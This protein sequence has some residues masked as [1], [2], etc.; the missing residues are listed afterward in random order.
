MSEGFYKY[1]SA[2][3]NAF[4]IYIL[5]QSLLL[6][7]LV[8]GIVVEYLEAF[9]NHKTPVSVFVSLSEEESTEILSSSGTCFDSSG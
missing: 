3:F 4:V 8:E 7:S 6:R 2:E 5:L 9:S 1:S